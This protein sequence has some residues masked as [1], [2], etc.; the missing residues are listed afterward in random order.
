MS[1]FLVAFEAV[2]ALLGIGVLGFWVIGRRRVPGPTL[3]FLSSLAI[4]IA[5]P[6]LVLGNLI[7]DFS[8]ENLPGWWKM[9][10]WWLGFTA[11]SLLLSLATSFMVKKEVRPE[12]RMGLFYQNGLFFPLVIITGLFGL[13]NPYLASL[14]IF[15]ALHPSLVFSTYT[16][17]FSKKI[18][19]N[20]FNWRRVVN[21]VLVTTLIG[22]IIGLMA[23]NRHI[24]SFILSI[25]TM[26]GAMAT[27]LFMLILGG[28]IYNDLMYREEGKRRFYLPEVAR[29][30]VMK[31]LIFPLVF[32]GLL[33]LL[34]PDD[35]TAFLI[36]LQ[37]AVPPITAIPIFAERCGGNRSVASQFIVGSFISSVISI[38]AMIYLFSMFFAIPLK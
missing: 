28:N 18:A 29:F 35:T 9:P 22:I 30:V 23:V 12:F 4:D 14:F 27:P 32:L 15:M 6:F 16:L 19:P 10:L 1:L 7:R 20:V 31:N 3:A 11:V 25:L 34:R 2:F 13:G 5:L 17:F 26:V 24:P 8:T 33:V 36:L 37:A 38:P 21:P